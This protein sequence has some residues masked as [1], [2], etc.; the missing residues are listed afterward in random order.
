M[1]PELE[2]VET[3]KGYK[4]VKLTREL[5]EKDAYGI[6]GFLN[7]GLLHAQRMRL[8][9]VINA[10]GLPEFQLIYLE[11]PNGPTFGYEEDVER[12]IFANWDEFCQT[13]R[14]M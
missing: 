9:C 11:D 14:P 7:A 12:T 6:L 2:F 3:E 5:V 1:K 4:A 8:I 13:L 10:A